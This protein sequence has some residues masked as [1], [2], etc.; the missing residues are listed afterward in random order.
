M[1]IARE[2]LPKYVKLY[3]KWLLKIQKGKYRGTTIFPFGIYVKHFDYADMDTFIN[4]EHI[5]WKQQKEMLAI[6]F[7]LWYFIE[8]AVNIFIFGLNKAYKNISFEQEA[9]DHEKDMEYLKTRKFYSW[10]KYLKYKPK[11]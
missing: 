7:Y 5:H 11:A 1:K 2:D 3:P 8:Y 6:P 4:H 9:Y 10:I